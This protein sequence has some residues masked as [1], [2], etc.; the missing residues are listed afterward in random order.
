MTIRVQHAS[1][2][3]LVVD[4]YDVG[5]RRVKRVAN[6]A[7]RAPGTVELQW[8]GTDDR[9]ERTAS[10]VYFLRVQSGRDVVTRKLVQ[11]K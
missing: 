6:D 8:D 3:R 2:A 11:I 10:G 7:S 5:G 1:R 9:G 4:I